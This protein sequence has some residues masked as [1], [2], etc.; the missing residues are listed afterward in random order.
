MSNLTSEFSYLSL[1]KAVDMK[2]SM[3]AQKYCSFL[4]EAYLM[5]T[6]RRFSYKTKCVAEKRKMYS[7]DD[8]MIAAKAFQSSPN[9]GKLF[10]NYVAVQ[11]KR[12]ELNSK[13]N[14]YYWRNL[15]GEEVDFVIKK[16]TEV[17]ELIQA[18]YSLE[19]AKTREREIRSLLKAGKELRCNRLTVLS[20][21]ED[22]EEE[23]EW[24]GIKGTIRYKPLV[25]WL[26]E[27]NS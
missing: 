13:L 8:G 25:K 17:T 26:F 4:E 16:G 12:E 23:H 22:K 18:C 10:E 1:A 14:F 20:L 11:L 9:Y 3:T 21:R 24:F 19:D 6:L 5:F 27:S 7:Y 2:S 15:Q